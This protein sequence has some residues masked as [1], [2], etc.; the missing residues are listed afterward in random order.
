MASPWIC[1][2]VLLGPLL[3]PNLALLKARPLPPSL[4]PQLSPLFSHLSLG[5]LDLSFQPLDQPGQLIDLVPCI[6]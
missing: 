5:V 4:P 6:T 2:Q 3:S 1:V